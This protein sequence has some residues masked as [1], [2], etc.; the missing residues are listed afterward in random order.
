MGRRIVLARAARGYHQAAFAR[1]LELSPQ[2]LNSY[3]KGT[4]APS[5]FIIAKVWQLTGATADYLLLGKMDGMPAELVRGIVEAEK[6]P[7]LDGRLKG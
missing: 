6:A 1:L 5:F 7:R 4:T 3:E 2:S